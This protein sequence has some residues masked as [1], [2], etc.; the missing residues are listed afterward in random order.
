[1]EKPQDKSFTKIPNELME[2]LMNPA[3]TAAEQKIL[4]Y[5]ARKTYGYHKRTDQISY[6]QFKNKLGLSQPTL[7]R[8]ISRLKQVKLLNLVKR[9]N[10]RRL[11]NTWQIDVS[12][13]ANKLVKLANLVYLTPKNPV[14]QLNHTKE[15]IT[16]ETTKGRSIL[17]NPVLKEY[18]ELVLEQRKKQ[19]TVRD[20]EHYKT[21]VIKR[22]EPDY[23]A[24][25]QLLKKKEELEDSDN[26]KTPSEWDGACRKTQAIE[27]QLEE[28]DKDLVKLVREE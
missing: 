17:D 18:A 20:E 15:S 16:K 21:A 1:M 8:A 12:D 14:K 13:Y 3:L 22:V 9:G 4:L 27:K 28:F 5:V 26:A 19:I 2:V 25:K 11:S 6:S 10:S 24:I 7:C 23:Q